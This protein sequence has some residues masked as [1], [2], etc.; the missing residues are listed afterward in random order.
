MRN[1]FIPQDRVERGMLERLPGFPQPPQCVTQPK[2]SQCTMAI[3]ISAGYYIWGGHDQGENSILGG[4]SN[5]VFWGSLRGGGMGSL[6][7]LTQA[8]HHKQPRSLMAGHLLHFYSC[9]TLPPKTNLVNN[10]APPLH[11]TALH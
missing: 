6:L 10:L 5:L 2:L 3:H 11:I 9:N 8:E 7:M 4:R 1:T